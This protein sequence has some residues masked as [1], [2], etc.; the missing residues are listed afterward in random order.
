M[1]KIG[2]SI[3]IYTYIFFSLKKILLLRIQNI[4]P[5]QTYRDVDI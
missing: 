2:E 1:F 5:Y 4:S 3:E